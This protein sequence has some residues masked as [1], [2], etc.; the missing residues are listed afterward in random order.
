LIILVRRFDRGDLAI[1]QKLFRLYLRSTRFINNWDLV[2]CSAPH[3]VGGGLLESPRTILDALARS[4]SLWERRIAVLAT[5]AFIRRGQFNDTLRLCRR[6]LNDPHDLM[7]KAC[8]W[9]LR[10]V[11][12]RDARVLH[13]FL[14][15]HCE[16]MPRTMLRYAIELLP[17]SQR[18]SYLARS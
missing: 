10:E 11:G 2:D 12:K 15:R 7:H 1:R 17:E 9:M 6:L 3:I 5:L 16:R 13:T 4:P 8:G 18:Q 14:D